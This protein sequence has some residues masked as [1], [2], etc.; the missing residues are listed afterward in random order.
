MAV[1]RRSE[2]TQE[3]NLT[4]IMN[5]VTIL[6]PFLIMAAQFVN[7]AVIDSTL[8]AIGPPST[9]PPDPDEEPPLN[10][11]LAVSAKGITI[12]GADKVLY[13]DGAPEIAEGEEKPPTV[14]CKSGGGCTGVDDYD[15]GDL[16]QKLGLI[17]DQYPDD[18][19]VILVPTDK[20]RYEILVKTMDVS[21]EDP[22]TKGPDGKARQLFPFVVI[23]GGAL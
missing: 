12:L 23:A 5:L 11:S 16:K 21:R 18:Q 14:P 19:N 20:L 17:K 9:E 1:K 4:P 10:L 15:W 13:P 7:L 3:L 8:P 2:E 6:I 22:D